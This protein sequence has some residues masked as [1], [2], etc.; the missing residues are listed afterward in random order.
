MSR[1]PLLLVEFGGNGNTTNYYKLVWNLIFA[2]VVKVVLG[3][4]RCNCGHPPKY[5]LGEYL[6][7]PKQK[8]ALA[9]FCL[10][11]SGSAINK[12]LI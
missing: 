2:Q 6:C 4:D 9:A 11:D 8:A 5:Y 1:A 7:D 3:S 10:P 12:L